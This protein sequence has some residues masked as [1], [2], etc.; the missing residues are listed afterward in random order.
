MSL[1]KCCISQPI[2]T[3]AGGKVRA[4]RNPLRAK[5]VPGKGLSSGT[6]FRVRVLL[7]EHVKLLD[8]LQTPN[9]LPSAR[10][11]HRHGL[12]SS[13]GGDSLEWCGVRSRGCAFRR[14]PWR[15]CF[16]TTTT[17]RFMARF[18]CSGPAFVAGGWFSKLVLSCWPLYT[19]RA[20]LV[21]AVATASIFLLQPGVDASIEMQQRD[22]KLF[23][24]GKKGP[25]PKP[26][27]R[28]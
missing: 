8:V 15:V 3:V 11:C 7:A 5:L 6:A 17:Q 19:D 24:K 28:R 21:G 2:V 22:A 25:E 1:A 14:A 13:G 23:N 10:V 16:P 4:A 27:K 9:G 18:P 26:Y 20:L 12:A